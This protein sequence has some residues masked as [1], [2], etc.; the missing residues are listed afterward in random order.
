[1]IC[2][3][4]THICIPST[5]IKQPCVSIESIKSILCCK[6]FIHSSIGMPNM[7]NKRYPVPTNAQY[8]YLQYLLES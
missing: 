3:H 8:R 1:M 5:Y 2:V 4:Y 6:S 7:Y